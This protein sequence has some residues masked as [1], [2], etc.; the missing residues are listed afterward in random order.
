ME[1]NIIAMGAR[2]LE[3][4]F[5][6]LKEFN[7]KLETIESKMQA[8]EIQVAVIE[9]NL[10]GL[11]SKI[12]NLIDKKCPENTSK[13]QELTLFKNGVEKT[14]ETKKNDKADITSTV[15]LI[16]ALIATLLNLFKIYGGK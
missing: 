13:I 8:I 14:N 6:F 5:N 10:D 2:E 16:S 9:N 7:R 3:E 1:G 15:A 4:L 11:D 12:S